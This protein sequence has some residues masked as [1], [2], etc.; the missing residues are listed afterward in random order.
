M[1]QNKHQRHGHVKDKVLGPKPKNV[2]IYF[3]NTAFATCTEALT[4]TILLRKN[5]GIQ[6][7]CDPEMSQIWPNWELKYE[8]GTPTTNKKND[9]YFA[10]WA[11]LSILFFHDKFHFFGWDNE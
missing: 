3:I 8:I 9:V 1:S 7:C 4:L 5:I 10:F 6:A 11:I 2:Q